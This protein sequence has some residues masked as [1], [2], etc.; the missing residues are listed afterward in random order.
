MH[1]ENTLHVSYKGSNGLL[2]SIK[3]STFSI[4]LYHMLLSQR[5]VPLSKQHQPPLGGHLRRPVFT[6]NEQGHFRQAHS[7]CVGAAEGQS[8]GP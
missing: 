2:L 8:E 6:P 5:C 1:N 7:V 4:T 3:L